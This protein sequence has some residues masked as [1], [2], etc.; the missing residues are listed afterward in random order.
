VDAAQV[1]AVL[2]AGG[3]VLDARGGERYRGEKEPIDAVGGHIPGA[4]S[5]PFAANLD[6][7]GRFLEPEALRARFAALL[8]GHAAEETICYCGS[9]VTGAHDLLAMTVAGLPLA[10]LYAGSWSDWITDPTRPIATGPEPGAP[11]TQA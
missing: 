8:D 6:D 4:I 5:A 11:P 1:S 2:A 10:R 3:R 9:G 7:E